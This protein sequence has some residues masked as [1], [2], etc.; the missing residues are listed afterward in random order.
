MDED[1]EGLTEA[2]VEKEKSLFDQAQTQD[3][4]NANANEFYGYDYDDFTKSST[5]RER[6]SLIE[7]GFLSKNE[8]ILA[9][10]VGSFILFI[11]SFNVK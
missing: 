5:L 10:L 1:Y 4:S 11:D 7:H 3:T 2:P 6:T 8:S 9:V